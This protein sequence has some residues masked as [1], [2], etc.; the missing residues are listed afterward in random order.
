MNW[1]KSTERCFVNYQTTGQVDYTD[2]SEYR[3][4]YGS[5]DISG[6][7]N[8]ILAS[9]KKIGATYLQVAPYNYYIKISLRGI[10]IIII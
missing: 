6:I 1:T 3:I 5:D 10:T 2:G 9:T 7:Y 4:Q 8:G